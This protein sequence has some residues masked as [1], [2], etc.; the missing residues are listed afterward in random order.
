[1]NVVLKPTVFWH[2]YKLLFSLFNKIEMSGTPQ[3]SGISLQTVTE[4]GPSIPLFG[5]LHGFTMHWGGIWRFVCAQVLHLRCIFRLQ[6]CL[7]FLFHVCRE[8]C[9][10]SLWSGAW[11][12]IPCSL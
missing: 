6:T 9:P 4:L 5:V 2:V 8:G 3:D 1:M 12:G 11:K 10:I 7:I